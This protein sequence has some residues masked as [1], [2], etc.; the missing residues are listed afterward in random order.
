M[1]PEMMVKEAPR[2]TRKRILIVDD[3]AVVREGLT[4]LIGGETDLTVCGQADS[5]SE[6]LKQHE[7]TMPDLSVIDL[8]LREGQG[9]D[10]IRRIKTR[11]KHAKMLVLSMHDESLYA[12]RALRAGALGFVA[13]NAPP[14]A[15]L[16]AIRQ[17]LAGKVYVSP[18]LG[19]HFLKGMVNHNPALRGSPIETLSD[20]ELEVFEMI[21]RGLSTREISEMLFLSV[22]TIESH[23]EHIKN[24]LGLSNSRE[25]SRH[26]VLWVQEQA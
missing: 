7:A 14:D 12:P 19:N 10:L 20:R 26:A 22:K 25:L 3:H 18:E 1:A 24:K 6:A 5:V 11:D 23:R 17:V 16:K 2:T 4:R 15:I 21:G 9:L 8:T 13:K